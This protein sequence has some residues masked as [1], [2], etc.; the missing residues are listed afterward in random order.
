[1]NKFMGA[2]APG[3]FALFAANFSLNILTTETNISPV[4]KFPKLH[5]CLASLRI[6]SMMYSLRKVSRMKNGNNSNTCT[7][8]NYNNSR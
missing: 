2:F 8:Y 6:Y 3:D 1:M 7:Y 4:N 5:K